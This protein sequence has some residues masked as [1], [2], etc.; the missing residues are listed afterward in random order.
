MSY[1][2]DEKMYDKNTNST[3]YC[4]SWKT[5]ANEKNKNLNEIFSKKDTNPQIL[6]ANGS[7]F[8]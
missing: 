7:G 8:I 5:V 4:P 2:W 6:E 3:Y 1:L